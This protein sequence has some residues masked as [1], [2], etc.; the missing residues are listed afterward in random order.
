MAKDTLIHQRKELR[1]RGKQRD[2]E[3]EN[4]KLY[5]IVTALNQML[6]RIFLPCMLCGR[7][8]GSAGYGC[9]LSGSS[10]RL[11]ARVEKALA[12]VEEKRMS[13]RRWDIRKLFHRE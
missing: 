13:L 11:G 8:A 10:T 6:G 1:G 7:V 4:A 9:Y 5:G 12:L 2:G 3:A